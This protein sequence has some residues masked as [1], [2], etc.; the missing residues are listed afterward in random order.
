[1]RI[2]CLL[3]AAFYLVCLCAG[4]QDGSLM[5][6]PAGDR[7]VELN[8]E[9]ETVLPNGRLITPAGRM[10]RIQPHP[11]GMTISPNGR[12]VVTANSGRPISLSILDLENPAEPPALADSGVAGGR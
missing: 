7:Y 1:M 2:S 11:Y 10:F 4:A 8:P 5:R 9:G 6:A 3:A 12:W